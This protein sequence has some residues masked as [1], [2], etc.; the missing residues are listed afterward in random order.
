MSVP[1][2]SGD[3]APPA[4]SPA[5]LFTCGPWSAAELGPAQL[6]ALQDFFDANPDYFVAVTGQPAAR[7][8]AREELHGVL[9]A[10]WPFTRK[11]VIAYFEPTNGS[12]D[13]STNRSTDERVN[14]RIGEFSGTIAA[15]A[16]IVSDL[17]AP[18]VWHIGLFIAATRLHGTGA[19]QALYRATED[20]MR[21]SGAAWVR[22]GVVAGNARAERFWAR[23]GY[24]ET[25]TRGGLVMGERVNTVR[26]MVKPVAGGA[27]DDYLDMV[28]RDRP[29]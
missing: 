6:P 1:T 19:A 4:A 13:G 29:D 10:G 26:V 12:A 8:E 9:P 17:L 27:L 7:D 3:S 15:M 24:A 21:R 11:W 18:G 2:P 20:W 25:R 14:E 23:E 22:L 5:P 16:T 28:A